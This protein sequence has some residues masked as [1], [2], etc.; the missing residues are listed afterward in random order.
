MAARRREWTGRER[1]VPGTPPRRSSRLRVASV[2]LSS[3]VPSRDVNGRPNILL[4]I[5]AR[6]PIRSCTSG[7]S[8]LNGTRCTP[9]AM[10]PHRASPSQIEN[11][12]SLILSPT[13]SA[14]APVRVPLRA[15]PRGRSWQENRDLGHVFNQRPSVS[16]SRLSPPSASR[17][18]ACKPRA[19]ASPRSASSPFPPAHICAHF[20]LSAAPST[21]TSRWPTEHQGSPRRWQSVL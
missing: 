10:L 8:P 17:A 13:R 15:G 12:A 2:L 5:C 1:A 9:S 4:T 16:G 11:L 7:A 18:Q 6:E 21:A 3:A 20:R 14:P 19:A